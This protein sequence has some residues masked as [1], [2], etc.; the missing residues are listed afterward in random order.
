MFGRLESVP[1]SKAKTLGHPTAALLGFAVSVLA[2]NNV[3]ALLK[4]V[5]ERAHCTTHPELDVSAYH[6]TVEISSTYEVHDI[7]AANRIPALCR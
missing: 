7:H 4:Q 3:L 6:L 5:T 2:Y 1:H